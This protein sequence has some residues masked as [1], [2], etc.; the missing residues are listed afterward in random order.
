MLLR[1]HIWTTNVALLTFAA[2]STGPALHSPLNLGAMLITGTVSTMVPDLDSKSSRLNHRLHLNHVKLFRHRGMMHSLPAWLV[3]MLMGGLM[4]HVVIKFSPRI[5]GANWRQFW[6]TV[7][8][9]WSL[10]YLCH[11]I[12]DS[13]SQ[14]GIRW[15]GPAT[16]KDGFAYHF[17]GLVLRQVHHYKYDQQTG[18]KIPVRHWWGRGYKVGGHGERRFDA[19]LILVVVLDLYLLLKWWL[20]RLV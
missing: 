14:A 20:L 8:L 18:K 15:W 2:L 7:L 16:P 1:S 4:Y 6:W 19:G 5:L 13:F 10:G 11:L 12:E 3:W 9:G 17:H